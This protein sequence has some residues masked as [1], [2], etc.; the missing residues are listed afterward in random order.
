MRSCENKQPSQNRVKVTLP[1][2][3]DSRIKDSSTSVSIGESRFSENA[4]ENTLINE[5]F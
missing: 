1:I 2:A 5:G 4:K 3:K